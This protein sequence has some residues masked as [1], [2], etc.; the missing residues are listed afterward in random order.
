MMSVF[1]WLDYDEAER[2][3]MKEAIEL[4]REHDT[5]DELG[6]GSV[7]DAF[8]NL[9]FPGTS[10]LHT[11]ARYLLFIPWIYIGLERRHVHSADAAE[12]ARRAE[13]SLIEALVAG[14]E[15]RD[16]IGARARAGL[17]QLPSEA[18]WTGL[19]VLGLRL[20][21]GTRA[22]YHR[23]FDAFNRAARDTPRAEDD[24]P[25][26]SRARLNWHPTLAKLE[27]DGYL[28][29]TTFA[30]TSDEAAYLRERILGSVPA[31]LFAFLVTSAAPAA[32]V[33]FPWVHP[34]V[35]ELPARLAAEL[36][37]ART[38]SEVMWGS[39]LL[40]NLMLAEL[41]NNEQ[42][43][44]DYDSALGRWGS[45][46]SPIPHRWE[47]KDFWEIALRGNPSLARMRRTQRFV[48]SWFALALELGPEVRN[49]TSARELIAAREWQVKGSQARLHSLSARERWTGAS[50]TAQLSYRWPVVGRIVEDI[51]DGLGAKGEAGARA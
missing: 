32:S 21:P 50:G 1:A 24:E 28:E 5:I 30:L 44:D 2:R 51:H 14:G 12:A 20:F 38:F 37:F 4:F 23:S 25:V 6:I 41:T 36:T 39:S 19:R 34:A 17:K 16:V 35:V 9:L 33:P 27:A 42:L 29:E 49:D 48:E 46:M 22:Q 47:W 43:I 7:R 10:V 45:T 13:V 18:Y 11:R 40:F 15:E 26:D 31:S 8:S 3:R